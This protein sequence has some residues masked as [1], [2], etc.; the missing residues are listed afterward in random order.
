M[1]IQRKGAKAKRAKGRK[2]SF[3]K[4]TFAF[5]APLHLCVRIYLYTELKV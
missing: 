1:K 5:L 3:K 4:N 2:E